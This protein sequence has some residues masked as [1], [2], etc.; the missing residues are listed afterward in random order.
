MQHI[1]YIFLFNYQNI[2]VPLF[3]NITKEKFN[4][5]EMNPEIIKLFF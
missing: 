5:I 1:K 4:N 2:Y 3:Y